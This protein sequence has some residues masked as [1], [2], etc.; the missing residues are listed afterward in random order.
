MTLNCA[1]TPQLF[2]TTLAL[3]AT[4]KLVRQDYFEGE[5]KG[6]AI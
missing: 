6:G 5:M 2:K 1:R 4:V 3:N